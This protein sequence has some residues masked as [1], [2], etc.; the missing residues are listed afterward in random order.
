MAN[1]YMFY[2]LT[3]LSIIIY[4]LYSN[5]CKPTGGEEEAG[6]FS[7]ARAIVRGVAEPCPSKAAQPG[8]GQSAGE[9][10]RED[11]GSFGARRVLRGLAIARVRATGKERRHAGQ[12]GRRRHHHRFPERD[13]GSEGGAG[14]RRG[15]GGPQGLR[16]QRRRG[17]GH[18][19]PG[20]A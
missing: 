2:V 14:E 19:E 9:G 18:R 7:P 6:K 20:S 10:A 13:R 3:K 5:G 16:G 11:K 12:T 17:A 8:S 4:T 15:G 1:Y